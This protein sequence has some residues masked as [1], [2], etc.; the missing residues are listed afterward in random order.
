MAK[1]KSQTTEFSLVGQ[2]LGLVIKNGDRLKYLRITVRERE[3]WIKPPKALRQHLPPQ[4]T[5]GCWLEISGQK[6]KCLKT[7]KIKLKA[8]YIGLAG[9][10]TA[11]FQDIP[12]QKTKTK[13]A[14]ASILV[15]QKSSCWR[16][17]GKAIC[18]LLAEELRERGLADTVQIKRTGCLKRC[19]RG[20]NLVFMPDKAR[21]SEVKP[22]QVQSLLGQH[23][24]SLEKEEKT[25]Q[26]PKNLVL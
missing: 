2:L 19:K 18:Q 24:G 5:P 4:I 12:L 26:S 3:Y 23:F 7:G 21:Y 1:S 20:P 10:N 16:R 11:Q 8:D 22:Q 17:G 6:E 14:T 15:C 13:S 9:V 25:P